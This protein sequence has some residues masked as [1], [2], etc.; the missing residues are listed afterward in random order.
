[1][2]IACFILLRSVFCLSNRALEKLLTRDQLFA[3]YLRKLTL[4]L[5]SIRVIA[6]GMGHA[7]ENLEVIS[8][9][10]SLLD[11]NHVIPLLESLH[12]THNLLELSLAGNSITDA[13]HRHIMLLLAASKIM[14]LDIS[15]NA[16]S[17][18]TMVPLARSLLDYPNLQSVYA[19]D[20]QISNA[21]GK[22]LLEAF[23]AVSSLR[24]V[25]ISGNPMES[26]LVSSAELLN[27]MR[28]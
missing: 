3:L 11:D 18:G 10:D 22:A 12:N 21:G 27:S 16:I 8:I 17:D 7:Y 20:N 6:S 26:S 24:H 28:S 15:R 5:S 1:V 13:S 23:Q 25:D 4:G 9:T 2:L 14:A 19:S